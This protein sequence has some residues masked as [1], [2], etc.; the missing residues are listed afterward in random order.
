MIAKFLRFKY[1]DSSCSGPGSPICN[2]VCFALDATTP[3]S[4]TSMLPEKCLDSLKDSASH[5]VAGPSILSSCDPRSAN[6]PRAL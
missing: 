3:L 6:L 1:I 5:C 2:A 4:R